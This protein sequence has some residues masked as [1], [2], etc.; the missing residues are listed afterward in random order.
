MPFNHRCIQNRNAATTAQKKIHCN[1]TNAYD[2]CSDCATPKML[3]VHGLRRNWMNVG[4]MVRG[5][6]QGTVQ[7]NA[8]SAS[9]S[10]ADMTKPQVN[11][12]V[13]GR[14][15]VPFP[16]ASVSPHL[17]Q[18]MPRA[19]VMGAMGHA[20]EGLQVSNKVKWLRRRFAGRK[21]G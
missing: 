10:A 17:L 21:S 9:K 16:L 8:T 4:A 20:L 7:T 2:R 13:R 18:R 12:F 15:N 6:D 19:A 1:R 3:P 5:Q 11:M 14:W